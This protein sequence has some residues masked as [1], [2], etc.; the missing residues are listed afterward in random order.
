M[1]MNEF[2]KKPIFTLKPPRNRRS[3]KKEIRI[4]G[5]FPIT[6]KR[7]VIQ[8]KSPLLTMQTTR[9]ARSS[10]ALHEFRTRTYIVCPILSLFSRLDYKDCKSVAG[11]TVPAVLFRPKSR[12]DTRG[13]ALMLCG[14][15]IHG[16]CPLK[17]VA[18]EPLLDKPRDCKEFMMV[19]IN[20]E[21]HTG[22]A[23]PS[24]PRSMSFCIACHQ[25]NLLGAVFP[26]VIKSREI[27]CNFTGF[28]RLRPFLLIGAPQTKCRKSR[29]TWL[30]TVCGVRKSH[31][32]QPPNRYP[33]RR[34]RSLSES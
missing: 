15:V 8:R 9:S 21:R 33:K 12:V 1:K 10:Q 20:S 26:K 11:A 2:V 32:E 27:D 31:G 4:D 5:H 25:S 22:F 7:G 19:M 6:Q 34:C 3:A 14:S 18:N 13:S 16:E 23:L 28:R 29:T 24:Y 17:A 30:E